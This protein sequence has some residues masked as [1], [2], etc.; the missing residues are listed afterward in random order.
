MTV[1]DIDIE[2]YEED[3]DFIVDLIWYAL[4]DDL[5]VTLENTQSNEAGVVHLVI[6]EYGLSVI[7]DSLN[8]EANHHQKR[9]TQE[10]ACEIAE[11]LERYTYLTETN[12]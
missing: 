1:K 7:I 6:D 9:S 10:R 5:L 11:K 8:L 3:R 12:D 4:P 2:L